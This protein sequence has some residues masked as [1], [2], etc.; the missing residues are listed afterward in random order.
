VPRLCRGAHSSLHES[1]EH[2][3]VGRI[4]ALGSEPKVLASAALTSIICVVFLLATR[5]SLRK[6]QLG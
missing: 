1:A 4:A 6:Y 3:L 2:N 5:N